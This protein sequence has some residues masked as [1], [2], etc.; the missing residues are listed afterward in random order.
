MVFFFFFMMVCLCSALVVGRKESEGPSSA[1]QTRTPA[2]HRRRTTRLLVPQCTL[3]VCYIATHPV[4]T[5]L[6]QSWNLVPH[7]AATSRYR[8]DETI[9]RSNDYF[10]LDSPTFSLFSLFSNV[11]SNCCVWKYQYCLLIV[12]LSFPSAFRKVWSPQCH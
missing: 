7:C 5:S 2:P 4:C 6:I 3:F 12:L 11:S 9:P 1:P 10:S 8:H